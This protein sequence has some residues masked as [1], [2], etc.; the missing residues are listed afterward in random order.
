[1]R[2][3]PLAWSSTRTRRAAGLLGSVRRGWPILALATGA[4]VSAI[5]ACLLSRATTASR[6]CLASIREPRGVDV[7]DCRREISG[8]VLPSRVPWTSTPARYRA[9]ELSTR[10]AIAA[11]DDAAIGHP[12]A[13]ALERTGEG[14]VTAGNTL[15]AGSQ[16]VTLAELG[17]TVGAPDRGQSAMLAGDRRTLTK[18]AP[19]WEHGSVRL[20]AIEA[21]LLDGDVAKAKSI[22]T[23][24]LALDPH[25]EEL[26]V[27]IGSLLCLGEGAD[28][29]RSV[30]LF[31]SVETPRAHDRHESWVRN[32]GD[33][34]ALVIACAG[35]AKRDPPPAPDRSQGGADDAV[36]ARAVV[37]LG[38]AHH[39]DGV[40]DAAPLRLAAFEALPIL[41]G[42][43][44]P[45]GV[46]VRVLASLLA[47]E[48]ELEPA[49]VARLATPREAEGEGKILPAAVAYTAIDWLD[50]PRGVHASPSRQA[51]RRA[52]ERLRRMMSTPAISR[53]DR[54]ALLLAAEATALQ[55]G[56]AFA[57]AG[58]AAGAVGILDQAGASA[59]R[60]VARSSAF[61]VAGDPERALAELQPLEQSVPDEM[62]DRELDVAWRIQ[63]AWLLASLGRLE[64]ASKAAL[65]ADG[66]ASTLRDR[67]LEVTALWT[68]L[69]FARRQ[70][71]R[72]EPPPPLPGAR[73][74]PWSGEIATSAS[75]LGPG[76]E[77]PAA[78]DRA[79]GAWA[80]AR[81]A[82]P[83]D[84]RALRYA[85]AT[86]HRGDAPRALA[87]YLAIAAELLPRGEGDV[88]VWLDAFSSTVARRSTLRAYA[89]S[90]A[91]AARFRGDAEAAA[92]WS[93]VYATLVQLAAAP[94]DAELAASLGI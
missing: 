58:D 72:A 68:R 17:P 67:G 38:L 77:S 83:E 69:A 12:D 23:A 89:W 42:G 47:A 20:R 29:D 15:Q 76:A 64:E 94:G 19:S 30:G 80:A 84:K 14:L 3:R 35:K 51:L 54:H 22:A 45:P 75:W 16:R 88:E 31:L 44:L 4:A 33:V 25:D 90:R 49:E 53:E 1:M 63:R 50:E 79:L 5:P 85:A 40:P 81:Q 59:A 61:Y 39:E 73:A 65:V 48:V 26:R 7:P 93:K 70:P 46:R 52:A 32:W 92:R 28:V 66:L 62:R 21:A 91:E 10:V 78:L 86:R 57:L 43:P 9:E 34:R 6:A 24:Y 71:L 60:A 41:R 13:A 74:W 11:Y 36:E 56:R 37:R 82:S 18:H 55:A 2:E 27:A 87:P 8:F